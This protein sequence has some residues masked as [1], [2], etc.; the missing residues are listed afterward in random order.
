MGVSQ[1]FLLKYVGQ[2][3][4]T[5]DLGPRPGQRA[6]V[7]V[8]G[9]A[10]SMFLLW[11]LRRLVCGPLTVVH[12]NHHT[13][14]FSDR[15]Q[16]VVEDYA[17]GLELKVAHLP[18]DLSQGNVE[19]R[20]RQQRYR[21]FFSQKTA[22]GLVYLGHTLTDSLEWSWLQSLKSGHPK[23]F[24][25]IPL[26]AGPIRRP[27]MGLTR[28]QVRHLAR[29][30]GVPFVKDPSNLSLRFDRNFV[31]AKLQLFEK[32]FPSVQRQYAARH[33]QLAFEW[34]V[35]RKQH[36]QKRPSCL[37]AHPSLGGI[38][39]YHKN[40]GQD[41]EG[42]EEIIRNC[43]CELSSKGRGSL[44]AQVNKMVQALKVGREGPFFFSGGVVCFG[45][46]RGA[47][48]LGPSQRER[49]DLYDRKMALLCRQLVFHKEGAGGR[50]KA[51]PLFPRLTG[52]FLSR[53]VPWQICLLP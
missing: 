25:G 24:L 2:F 48:F 51:H 46:S 47:L 40:G 20:G 41:F 45:V 4:A 49:Y 32:R 44:T 43:I 9:G 38:F 27:L 15:A 13:G 30:L 10:D 37:V 12:V 18:L 36:L 19:A 5:H 33:N 53:N 35:H 14:E 52:V 11:S 3:V 6:L 7:A 8:S 29:A 50:R 34:N 1:K 42:Q 28:G 39:L 16:R 31:R 22:G 23:S 21:W 17:R 26:V